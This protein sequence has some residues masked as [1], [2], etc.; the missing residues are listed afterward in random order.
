MEE[1]KTLEYKGKVIPYKLIRT[2]VKNLYIYI[3]DGKVTVKIPYVLSKKRQEE[4]VNKKANWISKKLEEEK[5]KQNKKEE[6][7]E[8]K[9]IIELQEFVKKYVEKYSKILKVS[10]NKVRI[11]NI[12]YA[13]GSCSVNKNITINSKLA[14]KN[15]EIVEYVVLH[16]MCHLL[17]MNH[18]KKFWKLVGENIKD[19]KKLRKELNS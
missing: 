12:K 8:E 19:Y 17:E 1:F 6:K 14:I 4:F 18:S 3:K 7:I 2:K 13:W 9:D 5:R 10:P 15:E 16:E 11:K